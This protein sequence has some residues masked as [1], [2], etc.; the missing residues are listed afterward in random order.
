MSIFIDVIK[1]FDTVDYQI[2]LHRT[3]SVGINGMCLRWFESYL[4]VRSLKVAL[5]DVVSS[6]FP[7]KWGVPQGSML[8]RL[9]YLVYV[10]MVRFYLQDACITSFADYTV[11]TVF[12]KSVDDLIVKPNDA[13][14]RLEVFTSLS[15]LCVNVK[16]TFLLTFCRVGDSVD[17]LKSYQV[18]NLFYQLNQYVT[19]ASI[20]ILI[21]RGSIIAILI[22]PKLHVELA[23]PE[24]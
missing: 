23:S 10:N 8:G 19:L 3:R 2:L 7:V 16:K 9:L 15:L 1:A 14:K 24:D 5:N 17:A 20:L 4:Y 6:S 13:L 18:K 21:Y 12:A 22:P 11:R